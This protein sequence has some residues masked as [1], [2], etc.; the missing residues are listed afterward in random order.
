[1]KLQEAQNSSLANSLQKAIYRIAD[2]NIKI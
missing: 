2:I 1:M